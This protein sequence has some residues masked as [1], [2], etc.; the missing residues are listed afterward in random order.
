M[1][2]TTSHHKKNA[3]KWNPFT[4]LVEMHN[5]DAIVKTSLAIPQKVKHRNT[6]NSI[7]RYITK[8]ISKEVF[9]EILI[10]G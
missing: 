4:L 1:C 7:H 8:R 9:K 6:S 5:G 2:N 10:Y 3:V